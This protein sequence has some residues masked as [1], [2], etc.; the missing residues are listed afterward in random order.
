MQLYFENKEEDALS[1]P[2]LAIKKFVVWIDKIYKLLDFFNFLLFIKNFS[3]YTLIERV[4]KIQYVN[5][6]STISNNFL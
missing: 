2:L 3:Y 6:E 4:L 5:F 1:K